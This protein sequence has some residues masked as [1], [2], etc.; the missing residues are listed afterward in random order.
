MLLVSMLGRVQYHP[1]LFIPSYLLSFL[2]LFGMLVAFPS[3]WPER[4]QWIFFAMLSAMLRMAFFT[5]PA[6][7][8]VYRYIWEGYILNNGFNPYLVAPE[9]PVLKP[10]I[11]EIWQHISHKN[12][13]ACYPPFA[14][15][16]FRGAAAVSPT[17]P[18]FKGLV[19]LFDSASIWLLV[20]L[21]RSRKLP[22]N[23]LALYALNPLVLVYIAGEG[24]LDVI[25]VFFILLCLHLFDRNKP[26]FAFFSLG[27]GAM[28]KYFAVLVA[29]FLVTS[30]NWKKTVYL[31]VTPAICYLPF[32]STG[33]D[34][35][36]SLVLL[37]TVNSYND[38]IA[39]ILRSLLGP[40]SVV[41]SLVLL[42][43]CLSLIFLVVH[44]PLRSSYLTFGCALLLLSTL[45]PWYL[46]LV[47]PFL[48]FFP[49]WAWLYLMAVSIPYL[50]VQYH[51]AVFYQSNWIT[52][53]EYLPFY[54]M[55][56]WD[57]YNDRRILVHRHFRPASTMSVVIPALNESGKIEDCLE[58][59][60]KEKAVLETIVADGGSL[61]GTQEIAERSGAT[62]LAAE[63]GRG[64]Q[65]KAAIDQCAGDIILILHADCLIQTDMTSKIISELNSRSGYVGGALEMQYSEGSLT[66]RFIALLNNARS[67]WTG[68]SFGDQAQFFRKEALSLIGGYPDLMLME[69]V[70]LSMRLK[71]VGPLLFIP[72]GVVVS[73]R[74]WVCTGFW[75]NSL[76]VVWICFCYLVQRRLK[77][78]ECRARNFY[79]QYY[80]VAKP[81]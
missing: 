68:I 63:R 10:Y 79:Q 44:E 4:R 12:L 38:S 53:F 21:I 77:L 7:S 37:G 43:V 67:R 40:Y 69:D 9:N 31:V 17:I 47:A 33:T 35:F 2:F 64:R 42:L 56:I 51:T 5:Y 28:V 57:T 34:L 46:V 80:S 60:N 32:W 66:N 14:M 25:Q 72:D 15:L 52:L 1:F 39:V 55:V 27:C 73:E 48:P 65:V 81:E 23:R 24:H 11:N 59:L 22:P 62:V 58:R 75:S 49:S 50:Y 16:I 74:R 13:T 36:S 3:H 70:E 61:D 26:A 18:C 76:R 71:E 6:S 20:L 41:G 54:A 78:T 8:D 45:N 19:L 29:P 30:K